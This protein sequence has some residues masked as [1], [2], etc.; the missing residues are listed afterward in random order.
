MTSPVQAS[1]TEPAGPPDQSRW[2]VAF[3]RFYARM[4]ALGAIEPSEPT[5]EPRTAAIVAGA[6]SQ[7]QPPA[8]SPAFRSEVVRRVVALY[9]PRWLVPGGA[10]GEIVGAGG[11]YGE[12][13]VLWVLDATIARTER[14]RDPRTWVLEVLRQRKER[15]ETAPPPCTGECREG[16]VETPEG[17]RCCSC[18][19]GRRRAA[20]MAREI[21]REDLWKGEKR[22]HAKDAYRMERTIGRPL[23][24]FLNP[25][26]KSSLEAWES[27]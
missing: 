2:T 18:E 5:L 9:E 1:R 27:R 4:R 11:V 10:I 7:P 24:S 17:A 26:E 23:G 13:E 8:F 21:E 19:R 6:R 12:R 14:P 3:R 22:E 15:G 25:I 16:L 20:T